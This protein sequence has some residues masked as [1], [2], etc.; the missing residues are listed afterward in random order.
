MLN[1]CRKL[2]PHGVFINAT[3]YLESPSTPPGRW[4]NSFLPPPLP[5]VGVNYT[6]IA[7]GYHAESDAYYSVEYDCG[8]T[9]LGEW[10]ADF[11]SI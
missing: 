3:S 6:I 7:N 11:A 9:L 4:I 10:R 5:P 2:T 1:S 8:N